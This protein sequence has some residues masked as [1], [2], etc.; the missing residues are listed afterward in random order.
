MVSTE[1]E[2]ARVAHLLRARRRA[3]QPEDVGLPRGRR[4]RTPGLRREEVAALCSMSTA[5]YSRLERRRL[6]PHCGPRPSPTML[7]RIAR[8]LRFSRADRDQLFSAAG[9]DLA[10]QVMGTTHVDPGLMHVLGR[11]ADTPA[12]AIDAIGEV[13][14]Q[15]RSA[16]ALFGD[17]TD[18]TEWA[19]SSYYRWFTNPDERLR[20]PLS[21]HSLIGAE[22]VADLRRHPEH[23]QGDGLTTDL[24]RIL[25]HRSEEFAEFWRR[26]PSLE[27]VLAAR[28]C[29]VVHP[30]LGVIDL[31]H[32]FDESQVTGSPVQ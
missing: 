16:R 15:T 24:V 13:L 18:Y 21:E 11:L 20:H 22:I 10:R 9:Y 32:R 3:L 6:E 8:A 31:Q 23:G 1:I 27:G 5:Y 28:H 2:L 30:G 4:R 19:R 12:L 7:A 14:Y 29:R 26:E 17:L 25:L